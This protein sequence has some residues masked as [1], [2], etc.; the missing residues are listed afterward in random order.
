[1]F[2]QAIH[3]NANFVA[4]CER[5]KTVSGG[6]LQLLGLVSD[7]GVHAHIEHLYSLLEGAKVNGVPTTYVH[8]FSDGRDTSPTSG[9][10]FVQAVLDRCK[11]LGYGSLATIMGRYYAMDRDKRWERIQL[12]VEGLVDGVGEK[13]TPEEVV[14]VVKKNYANSE[15]SETKQNKA[16]SKWHHQNNCLFTLV[17]VTDE[18]LK[19]IIVNSEGLLRDNDTLV[20]IDYRADR[21]RQITET[22]GIKTPFEKANMP[23]GL[24]LFTMTEYKKE[25]PFR[26]L[27]PATVPKNVLAEVVSAAGWPQFHTAETE[28]YA[29]VTFFFNGGQEKAFPGEERQLVSS[30]KVATY[31]LQPEMSCAGVGEAV[32]AAVATKKYPFVMCNFAPPDMVGHTGK[33]EPAVKAC[34]ATDRAIG[35]IKAACEAAGYA[36]LITADHGN[37]EKMY[38]DKGGPLTSHTTNRV[39]FVLHNTTRQFAIPPDHNAALCDVAPTVLDLLGLAIP[40]ADMTGKSLL[41]K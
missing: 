27:Y 24:E 40:A 29:H 8:F 33:Y 22:I 6:R 2:S 18:F 9:A 12:A 38:D 20:F 37:A 25:F 13:T 31:D 32:A 3:K 7:G 5:A 30:P 26:Q 15:Y 23:K 39:P 36:L 1:M 4:A 35:V 41:K 19:P 10:G 11:A 21:M 17:D 28:K 16:V 34:A 14:A